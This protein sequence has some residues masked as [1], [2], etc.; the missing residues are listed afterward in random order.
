M[1]WCQYFVTGTF[2]LLLNRVNVPLYE[3]EKEKFT[4]ST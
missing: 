1:D 2:G 3:Y 4:D